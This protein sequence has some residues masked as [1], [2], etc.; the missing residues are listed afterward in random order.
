MKL[1]QSLINPNQLWMSG[2]LVHD[3]PT[4]NGDK[5]FGLITDN[6]FIPF[7][8]AGA[9]V[10]VDSIAPTHIEVEK[11]M[12][13]VIGPTEWN[14]STVHLQD[15]SQPNNRAIEIATIAI[16]NDIPFTSLSPHK[17]A[18]E[19]TVDPSEPQVILSIVS[20]AFDSQT[21]DQLLLSKPVTAERHASVTAEEVS[22]KFG[23]GLEPA[24]KTLK[25]TTQQGI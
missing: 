15:S 1:S 6:L 16:G 20:T 4:T 13:P 18:L 17:Q 9:T 25:V 21:F 12:H 2:T 11:F 23:I 24:E 5:E 3:D 7:Q 22:K 14:P 10:H 8:T 19:L